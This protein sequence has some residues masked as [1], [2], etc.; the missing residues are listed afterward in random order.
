MF[1]P[2]VA[3]SDLLNLALSHCCTYIG[4]FTVFS[5]IFNTYSKYIS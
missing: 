1:S 3:Y 5:L 4:N 2:S